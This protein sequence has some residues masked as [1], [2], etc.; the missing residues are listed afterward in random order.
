MFDQADRL[1]A[2][3]NKILDEDFQKKSAVTRTAP[4]QIVYAEDD[5]PTAPVTSEGPSVTARPSALPAR[6]DTSV[7]EDNRTTERPVELARDGLPTDAEQRRLFAEAQA[8]PKVREGDVSKFLRQQFPDIKQQYDADPEFAKTTD[9]ALQDYFKELQIAPAFVNSMA[10]NVTF[11]QADKIGG[12][13]ARLAAAVTPGE[14]LPLEVY[15]AAYRVKIQQGGKTWAG[16]AGDIAGFGVALGAVKRGFAVAN[17]GIQAAR[18]FS[19]QSSNANKLV[20][21]FKKYLRRTAEMGTT[22]GLQNTG[23]GEF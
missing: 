5:R 3:R 16:T 23:R 22:A 6:P 4:E 9:L 17:E 21:T 13:V 10:D 19:G 15:Q 7:Y 12:A 8:K 11:G 14:A 2:G 18:G 20:Q 1:Q